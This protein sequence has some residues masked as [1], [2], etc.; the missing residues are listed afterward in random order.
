[1]LTAVTSCLGWQKKMSYCIAFSAEGATDVTRRY[2]RRDEDAKPR[3]ACPESVLLHI[4]NEIKSARR[5]DI[6]PLK[7][8]RLA[9]EDGWEE[10]ELARYI[11]AALA[12]SITLSPPDNARNETVEE[13]PRLRPKLPLRIVPPA[14]WSHADHDHIPMTYPGDATT[15]GPQED[16]S[17]DRGNNRDQP[18]T[19]GKTH[20]GMVRSV[21]R[22]VAR[23]GVDS[24]FSRASSDS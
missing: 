18:M 24:A 3:T 20:G 16:S 17:R 6:S 19:A 7:R 9:R 14:T 1:M 4:L 21:M 15:P 2:V 12:N 22:L 11:G 5:A 13:V 23:L 8:V 10:R